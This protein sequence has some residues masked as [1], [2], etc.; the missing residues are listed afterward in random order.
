MFGYGGAYGTGRICIG[1]FGGC[2]ALYCFHG[3]AYALML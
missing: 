3:T 2:S 1:I